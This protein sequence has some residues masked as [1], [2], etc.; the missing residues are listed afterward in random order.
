MPSFLAASPLQARAAG[1]CKFRHGIQPNDRPVFAVK[2]EESEYWRRS[3]ISCRTGTA[4]T[5]VNQRVQSVAVFW[6]ADLIQTVER[7]CSS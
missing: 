4:T 7:S 2:R 5:G 6:P 3:R 1:W